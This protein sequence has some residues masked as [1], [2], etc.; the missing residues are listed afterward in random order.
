MGRPLEDLTNKK[1]NFLKV[2]SKAEKR[3]GKTFWECLCDCGNI[4][5]V[6]APHLKSGRI[7]SCGCMKVQLL[8][9]HFTVHGGNGSREYSSYISMLHRC[10]NDTRVGYDNYGGRGIKIC[11][12]WLESFKNFLQDMGERPEN[13]TLDR[14]D[15]DEGYCKEN[16]R[17]SVKQVQSHNRRKKPEA[18]SKYLGVCYNERYNK[19]SARITINGVTNFIGSFNNEVDAAK[20]Y[21]AES[22]QI[23]GDTQNFK[24]L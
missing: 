2:L 18:S 17:W 8:K 13:T 5:Q 11:D 20:A 3:N 10:Y 4:K 15:N 19:W 23:Y 22:L 21:D 9:D 1:F 16:C 6:A 24:G 14:I 12:R 7:K